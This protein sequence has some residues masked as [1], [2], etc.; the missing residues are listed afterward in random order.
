MNHAE[1]GAN[2]RI[3]VDLEN[4]TVVSPD[5]EEL[6][7]EIDPFKKRCLLEGLDDIALTL[8]KDAMITEFESR[9]RLSMPWL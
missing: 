4:Q 9:H 6:S 5:G 2:A 7:F 3:A 8:E 1:N